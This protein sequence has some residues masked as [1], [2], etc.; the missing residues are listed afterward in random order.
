[1]ITDETL[2]K[3]ELARKLLAEVRKDLKEYLE[4]IPAV[5][6]R[7]D[8]EKTFALRHRVEEQQAAIRSV[9]KALDALLELLAL[10]GAIWERLGKPEA[11]K[12]PRITWKRGEYADHRGTVGGVE[13]FAIH[14]HTRREDP[15]YRL[16]SPLPWIQVDAQSD[17][18]DALKAIAEEAYAT[19]LARMT[20]KAVGE[21]AYATVLDRM[22][23]AS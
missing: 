19:F 15:N 6:I 10:A 12:A 20:L 18:A 14:W 7:A 3:A 1:M 21:E 8:P 16:V 5:A 9:N 23:G 2:R 4:T 13:V 22:G 17:D 11:Q